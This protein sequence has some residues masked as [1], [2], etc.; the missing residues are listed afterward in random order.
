MPFATQFDFRGFGDVLSQAASSPLSYVALVIALLIWLGVVY[1]AFKKRVYPRL[2]DLLPKNKRYSAMEL[3]FLGAP[4][5]IT[6]NQLK[7][8]RWRYALAAYVATLIFFVLIAGLGIYAYIGRSFPDES[9]VQQIVEAA[10]YDQKAQLRKIET[11]TDNLARAMAEREQY[12]AFLAKLI[13]FKGQLS[14]SQSPDIRAKG[15]ELQDLIDDLLRNVPEASLTED[16]RDELDLAKA[17]AL[18]ASG[19]WDPAIPLANEKKADAELTRGMELVKRAIKRYRVLA[20]C[21]FQK[22]DWRNAAGAYGKIVSSRLATDWDRVRLVI[23]RLRLQHLGDAL[24][25]CNDAGRR[26]VSPSELLPRAS[27]HFLRAHILEEQGDNDTAAKAYEDAALGFDA[28][29]QKGTVYRELEQGAKLDFRTLSAQLY[30][31]RGTALEKVP[32]ALEAEGAYTESIKRLRDLVAST[33][34]AG[35]EKGK[36]K[37]GAKDNSVREYLALVLRGCS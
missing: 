6:D 33:S 22:E 25:V 10:T 34:E 24:T 37:V 16:V 23:C 15:K 20:W 5:G 30:W 26:Q 36:P 12:L 31:L 27:I 4:A 32:R 28:L 7:A 9:Q 29:V 11:A 1:L 19:Q 3:L 35:Q 8:L 17:L 21:H 2:L 14:A 18:A 13:G